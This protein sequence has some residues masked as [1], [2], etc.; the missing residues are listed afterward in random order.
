M[1]V[2]QSDLIIGGGAGSP[3]PVLH[4]IDAY[5]LQSVFLW[6]VGQV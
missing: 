6:K 4:G 3:S 2:S 1:L 5:A